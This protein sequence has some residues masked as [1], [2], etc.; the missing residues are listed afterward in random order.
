MN[1][2]FSNDIPAFTV[3]YTVATFLKIPEVEGASYSG[4]PS[5]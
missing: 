3:W 5:C 2:A 1:T 4:Q